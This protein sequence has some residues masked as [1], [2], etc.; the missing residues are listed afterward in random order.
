VISLLHHYSSEAYNF[1][2]TCGFAF[3][4]SKYR[5]FPGTPCSQQKN[6]I[7]PIRQKTSYLLSTE[8]GVSDTNTDWWRPE[9]ESIIRSAA[10]D[11]GADES[12]VDISWKPGLVTVVV[13]G[14]AR[15]STDMDIDG[16]EES[17]D[18]NLQTELDISGDE[19]SEESEE[20]EM[21]DE[22]ISSEVGNAPDIAAIAR[23]INFA[24]EGEEGSVGWNVAKFHEIEVTSPGAPEELTGVM[25]EVYKGFGII[26]DT[27]DKKTKKAIK[28]EGKFIERDDEFTKINVK[29]RVK[30]LKNSDVSSIRLPKAKKEKGAR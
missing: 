5:R 1:P 13:A 22:D 9:A 20:F 27:I 12:L 30:K 25:F 3:K 10:A 6:V 16:D 26:C 7:V 14:N 23:S 24:L 11:V 15:M 28:L 17:E 29:G 19:D 2:S 4:R 18:L 8:E 21:F